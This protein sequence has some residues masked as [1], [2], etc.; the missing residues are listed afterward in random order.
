M[1]T[2]LAALDLEGDSEAVLMRALQLAQAH[3]ARLV[4]LHVLETEGLGQA[5]A[6]YG[7]AE[8]GLR[9]LL[10]R[11]AREALAN[12]LDGIADPEILVEFGP[13][14]VVIVDVVEA[15][16]ADLVVM[17]PGTRA[18]MLKGRALGTT[19]DRVVRSLA[20]SLLVVRS[21]PELPYRQLTVAM[22]F[23]PQSTAA[24]QAARRLAPSAAVRL[25]HV[26]HVPEP[27]Q[28]AM[29]RAGASHADIESFHSGLYDKA[30]AD[31]AALAATL[32]VQ[33]RVVTRVMKSQPGAALL[34]M[35]K[36]PRTDLIAVGADGRGAV[37]SALLGSVTRRLLSEAGCDVLV[38]R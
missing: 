8:D 4:L 21:L 11:Q 31:L 16:G 7:C 33:G 24:L 3:S 9:G 25:V 18:R 15:I 36:G 23:S 20:V 19:V 35:S 29:L 13:A 1:D 2:I 26:A 14:H 37:R 28:Q 5:A 38:G 32:E 17:G 34:K 10:Q 30:R 12:L 27:F 6:A 22:D